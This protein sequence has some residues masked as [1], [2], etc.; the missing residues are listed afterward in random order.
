MINERLANFSRVSSA[1]LYSQYAVLIKS[2][3]FCLDFLPLIYPQATLNLEILSPFPSQFTNSHLTLNIVSRIKEVDLP[4]GSWK[5]S[6]FYRTSSFTESDIK[7]RYLQPR[8]YHYHRLVSMN[9]F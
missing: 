2:V 5:A 1:A 4:G 8:K 9:V 3:S 6:V 7:S